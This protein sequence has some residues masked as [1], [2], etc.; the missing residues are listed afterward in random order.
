MVM[1]ALFTTFITT[2]VVTTIYKPA[3]MTDSDY[4]HKTIQRKKTDTQ[5]RLL[6]CFDTA[7]SIP[8]LINLMEVSRGTGNRE[9]LR[10]YAMHLMEL[11]ERSSA[12]LTVHKARRNGM[13][14]WNRKK[15]PNPDQIVVAFEAFQHLSQVS[16]T[17]TTAISS[18]STMHE[19]ICNSAARKKVAMIILLFH[20]RQRLDRQLETTRAELRHVNRKVLEHSPCSVGILV[21]RGLGG[22]SHVPASNVDY[23]LT[24][25]F[26]GGNDDREALSYGAIMAEHPGVSLNVVRFLVD[27]GLAGEI[28]QLEM[29]DR[30]SPEEARSADEAFFAEFKRKVSEDGSIRLE[31]STVRNCGEAV[32]VM[33]RYNRSN[34]IIVGRMPEGELV[35]GLNNTRNECPELGPVGNVL[36]SPEFLGSVL[37][38]QQFRRPLTGKSLDSLMIPTSEGESDSQ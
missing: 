12:I 26:F 16:V 8:T 3:Q 1:M 31:E 34:L 19:D 33:R 22:T 15:N 29:D 36:I 5:L 17:P 30:D 10:V 14:F 37:V 13:P 18:M 27:P 35:A 23:T 20:K 28:I 6:T 11:S 38:V 24:A 4:K 25:F 9:G 2:P 7:R 21:D 32:A